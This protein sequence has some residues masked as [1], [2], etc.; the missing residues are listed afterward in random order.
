LRNRAVYASIVLILLVTSLFA[1]SS[2]LVL[3]WRNPASSAKNFRKI[4]VIGMSDK[5]EVRANFEDALSAKVGRPG[6]EAIPGNTIL[7]RPEGTKVSLDYI[8]DQVRSNK[9]D[10][11]L[12][13]RLVKIDK[14]ITYV[15]GQAFYPYPYYRTFYGYYG[16]VYPVVYSPGYLK[17]EKKIRIE[18]NFYSTATPDGELVWTGMSDTFNPSSTKKAIDS[19]VKLVV[20]ELE[21]EQLLG[22]TNAALRLQATTSIP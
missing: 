19:V 15:P 13:S 16:T 7:L 17:E 1:A 18:T 11:V 5:V 20:K 2:K 8:K 12:V 3:S 9:I 10:G 4:L 21:K 22:S 6:I 14:N